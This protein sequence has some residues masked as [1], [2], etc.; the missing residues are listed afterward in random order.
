LR[1]IDV[2]LLKAA[3]ITVIVGHSSHDLETIIDRTFRA[4][5]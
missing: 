4:S 2:F 5:I 3:T 1:G